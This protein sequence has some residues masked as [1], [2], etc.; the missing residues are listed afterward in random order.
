M[1]TEMSVVH[2]CA[3]VLLDFFTFET[4]RSD[5]VSRQSCHQIDVCVRKLLAVDQLWASWWV[6]PWLHQ[7]HFWRLVCL[8]D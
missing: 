8:L 1:T 4:A 3:H 6:C 5:L 7:R 2:V